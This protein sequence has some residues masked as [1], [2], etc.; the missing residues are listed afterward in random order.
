MSFRQSKT[1]FSR[2]R[3]L[4]RMGGLAMVENGDQVIEAL[5]L[6]EQT[7]FYAMKHLGALS[8]GYLVLSWIGLA[9]QYWIPKIQQ[10]IVTKKKLRRRQNPKPSD[11]RES[12]QPVSKQ[13]FTTPIRLKM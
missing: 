9:V 3:D 12:A 7:Y 11:R 1:L 8:A 4:P 2:F 13:S 6:G 5:G 10:S